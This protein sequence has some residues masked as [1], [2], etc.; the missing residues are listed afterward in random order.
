MTGLATVA[1]AAW[2]A[3]SLPGAAAFAAALNDPE[4]AQRDLLRRYLRRNANTLFGREHRLDRV[5][6]VDAYRRAVPARDYDGLVPWIDRIAAG[7]QGVLTAERV[8]RFVPSSGSTRAAKWVPYTAGLSAEFN[9]AVGPWIADL[10][11]RRPWLAGGPAYWSVTPV[12]PVA[13][14]TSAVPVGFDDD[15]AYLGG[16]RRRLVDAAM[17]V[18]SAVRH[19]HDF[20]AFRLATLRHLIGRADLRLISVWH[21]SFLELLLDFAAGHWDELMAS[22]PDRRRAADLAATGPDWAA[23]WP[24]LGLVSCWADAHAAG[25]AAALARRLPHAEVQPKGLLATEAFVS[26]P[27]A[28]AWPLAVRSH[29]LEFED[30]GRP[31]DA[32]DLRAGG[33][34]DVVV[35]TAGGLWRYRLGDRVRCDGHLGRTPSVRFVG[36]RDLVVD[37]FGEKLSEGFVGGVVRG[38]VGQA[39]F[40]LLAPDGAGYTLFVEGCNGVGRLAGPLDGALSDNPHYRYCRTLGQLA[41]ARVFVVAGG[42]Y[43]AYLARRVEGGQRVGDVKPVALDGWDGWAGRFTGEYEGANGP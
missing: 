20:D 23:V 26:V 37:R 32:A 5:T 28:G 11:G 16:V 29:L 35:T 31:V 40:A 2:W 43:A 30:D 12:V 18:P 8:T 42:G 9:R 38:L 14:G 1:T 33:E 19:V 17:A 4:R 25:P 21:P 13:A 24:R 34:Y 10:Y 36:R 22:V 15:A 7:E 27:F 6:S 39:P 41:A 3:A